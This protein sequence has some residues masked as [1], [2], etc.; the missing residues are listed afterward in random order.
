[1]AVGVYSAFIWGPL[2]LDMLSRLKRRSID[3]Y[4]S[5]LFGPNDNITHKRIW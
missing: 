4:A 2:E 5:G 3:V 1:M